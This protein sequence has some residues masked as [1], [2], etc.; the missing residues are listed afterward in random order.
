MPRKAKHEETRGEI[1]MEEKMEETI[2]EE[3]AEKAEKPAKEEAA[4]TKTKKKAEKKEKTE[5]V[6]EEVIEEPSVEVGKKEIKE[7][8]KVVERRLAEWIPK[9]SL[10]RAVV[11]GKYTDMKQIIAKG[12]IVLEPQIVDYLVPGL[13]EELVYIGGTPGK[14]G[15]IRR[16]PTRM[17]ARMHKSGR[18]FKLTALVVVGNDDGIIGIGKATSNEHRTAIEKAIQHAK[19]NVINVRRGCG[20]W[21]CN[22]GG[23]H[24]IPFKTRGKAG[25]VVVKLLPTPV[26]VGIVADKETKKILR[27]AGIKDV[28]SKISGMSS[29]RMNLALAVF[30]ALKNLSRTKGD[31]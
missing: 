6:I 29:T 25:S 1:E 13:R 12:E 8:I 16:T 10:G 23:T 28:W 20:S 9:T 5:D 26:G 24:S 31:I 2:K 17:T 7:A 27:L 11:E 22:C 30:E 4:A 15:G 14:G 18:R 21:E 3:K 19:L